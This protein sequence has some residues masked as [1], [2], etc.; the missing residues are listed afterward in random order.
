TYPADYKVI[1]IG[2]ASMSP[3]ELTH[4]GGAVEHMND[5]AGAL[6]LRRVNETWRHSVWLNP[7]KEQHWGYTQSIAMIRDIME[8]RMYPLTLE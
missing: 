2:D 8:G 3:Y 6:W 5:E 1:F 4:A 7:V